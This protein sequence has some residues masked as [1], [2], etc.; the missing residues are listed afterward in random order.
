MNC[1]CIGKTEKKIAEYLKPQAGEDVKVECLAT[2]ISINDDMGL[3]MAI[4]IPF[5]VKGSKKG[6]TSQK[7]KEMPVMASYC[8]FCSRD[9]RPGHYTVGQDDGIASAI[10][11][12]SGDTQL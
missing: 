10:G 8:P 11:M 7:G 1:D 6:F 3:H 4:R 9:T 5:S 12:G 2:A